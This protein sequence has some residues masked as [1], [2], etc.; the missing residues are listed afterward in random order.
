M[1]ANNKAATIPDAVTSEPGQ[2][3]FPMSVRE[4]LCIFV[5]YQKAAKK[6]HR[7]LVCLDPVKLTPMMIRVYLRENFRLVISKLRGPS[8]V[9]VFLGCYSWEEKERNAGAATVSP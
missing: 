6:G 4:N 8:V 7:N 9:T 2:S 3:R 1:E 5:N